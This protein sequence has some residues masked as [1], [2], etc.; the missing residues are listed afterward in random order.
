[1]HCWA[2]S[3][4]IAVVVTLGILSMLGACGQKGPLYLPEETPANT[5]AP[6][7]DVP[8]A[9]PLDLSEAEGTTATSA[10]RPN[11]P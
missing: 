3:L 4:F 10:T 5:P 9:P 8:V 11:P 6:G 1:M 2:R 7:A